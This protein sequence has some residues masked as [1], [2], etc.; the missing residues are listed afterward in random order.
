MPGLNLAQ[1]LRGLPS[2]RNAV[3][4]CIT[5]L[6]GTEYQQRAS[7]VGCTHFL[8]KPVEPDEVFELVDDLRDAQRTALWPAPRRWPMH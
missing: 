5:G 1:Q 2:M 8:V 3:L 7:Q 6:S 4:I